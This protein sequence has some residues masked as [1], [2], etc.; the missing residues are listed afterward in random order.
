[1]ASFVESLS[2][3]R[4]AKA[5]ISAHPAFP[6]IVALWFAALLGL[7]SLVL[8]VALI[9]RLVTVTRFSSIVSAAEPPLGFTARAGIALGASIAGALVGLWLARK[10]AVAAAPEPRAHGFSLAS[11]RQCRPISAPEELG[12][13][14]LDSGPSTP[15][16]QKRR[17]LAIAEDDGPS[18]Y[19]QA[20]PLPGQSTDAPAELPQFEAVPPSEPF[21]AGEPVAKANFEP[22]EL[23][24]YVAPDDD[25]DELEALRLQIHTLDAPRIERPTSA[26]PAQANNEPL[27]F[28][29]PSLRRTAAA[30]FDE[31]EQVDVTQDDND[32]EAFDD[33]W[34]DDDALDQEP[35]V[36]ESTPPLAIVVDSG[37]PDVDDRPVEELGL[38]QL[39]ARLGASLERRR[40]W[41]AQRP[42]ATPAPAPA[43]APFADGEDFEAAQPED[44]ARAMADFFG[45]ANGP[46]AAHAAEDVGRSEPEPEFDAVA[47]EQ[48]VPAPLRSVAFDADEEVDEDAI[49]ASLS[50]PLGGVSAHVNEAADREREEFDEGEPDDSE[51]SSLLEM[52]NPFVRPQE[53]VRV[54][55]PADESGSFEPAVTF[56][57]ASP[58]ALNNGAQPPMAS[59][60]RPF[61]PPKSTAESV[62]RPAPAAARR[63]P[64]D[65]E[66]SLRDALATLQRMS[67][68]A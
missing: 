52:K 22:L 31:E 2:D 16:V 47:R 18:S 21:A 11:A 63:D 62:H 12:D 49:G 40:A 51:Y 10:V 43:P 13:E 9:E 48:A 32:Y 17:S 20:V 24:A 58:A 5:P 57:S 4:T 6:A 38:V 30:E 26:K 54:E 55:E 61:D 15:P 14:G 45:S 67:G 65:A 29:A 35:F 68:A 33:E 37:E 34:S 53:F 36:A 56:P 66:R 42:S 28:A 64:G 27:P 7:G 59:A 41:L 3:S 19:L 23:A 39:A 8:P 25:E 46:Q 1:V 50:L 60:T 44:A